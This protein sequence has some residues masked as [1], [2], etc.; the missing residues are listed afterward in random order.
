MTV[1]HQEKEI[2]AANKMSSSRGVNFVFKNFWK[3]Q[4]TAYILS[5]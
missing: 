5:L 2:G 4:Y 3:L 1:K